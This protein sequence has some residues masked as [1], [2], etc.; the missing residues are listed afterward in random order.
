LDL[1][2]AWLER[3]AYQVDAQH[4]EFRNHKL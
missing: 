2:F 3:K 1:G 4:A